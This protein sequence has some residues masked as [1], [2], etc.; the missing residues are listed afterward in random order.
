MFGGQCRGGLV[1]WFASLL[2][3][4]GLLQRSWDVFV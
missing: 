1:V 2:N 4:P 3:R